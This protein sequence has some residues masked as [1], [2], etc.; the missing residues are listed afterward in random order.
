MSAGDWKELFSAACAGNLP[1]V[2][3][4]VRMGVDL[5]HVHPEFLSTPLVACLLE[6]Q[7]AVAHYLLDH[8]ARPD[9]LSELEG[10]TPL[11]AARQAGVPSVEQRLLALGLSAPPASARVPRWTRWLERLIA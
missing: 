3:Y 9:L 6:G 5:N 2:R 1:L 7:E 4:H 10:L 8:G 11:Q